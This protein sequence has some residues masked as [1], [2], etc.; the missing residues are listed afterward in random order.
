MAAEPAFSVV[1]C[2]HNRAGYLAE[3]IRSVQEQTLRPDRYEVIVV[4]NVST[5]G[6]RQI[7]EALSATS[8][9][10]V[11]YLYEERLGSS[12]ARNAGIAQ[13]KGDLLAFMD[14]DAV[15]TP[16]WLA[17]LANVFEEDEGIVCVG[18]GIELLWDVPRP[19]WYPPR[20]EGYLG[21]TRRFGAVQ[22]DLA[23]DEF[24][25]SG[26]LAVRR[27]AVMQLG[28]GGWFDP[29]LGHQG[30]RLGA[31]ED[32]WFSYQVRRYGRLVYAPGALVRHHVPPERATR[33]YLLR[34]A[35]LV[36]V[37]NAQLVQRMRPSS[38]WW[39]I[40]STGSQVRFLGGQIPVLIGNC[41]ARRPKGVMASLVLC[42]GR[43]GRI[44]GNLRLLLRDRSL[45]V[46]I[47]QG[48]GA[49]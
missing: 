25:P 13:A 26:N 11:R 41:L 45:V 27:Q 7:V 12:A 20:F 8:R 39:L 22:R 2:T 1:I 10:P 19:G 17:R 28:D 46:E 14:D 32:Y 30:S 29:A 31:H 35:Y 44:V 3:A 16:G 4:D 34:R 5:D 23:A 33:R 43:A 15:A 9:A 36:D 38:R 18:G 37:S 48:E 24:L 21:G 40:R 49:G 42:A 47:G 6:T